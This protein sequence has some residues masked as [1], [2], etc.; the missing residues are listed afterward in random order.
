MKK[1]KVIWT[2]SVLF[3]ALNFKIGRSQDVNLEKIVVTPSRIEE[4]Y[5]GS[6]RKVDVVTAKEIE[7][8]G[9]SNIAEALTDITSVN[10]SDY[11]GPGA[12]KT[13]KMRGSSASQVLVLVDGRSINS[14]RDGEVDLSSL[15]MDNTDRI[16]VMHG[17][18]SSLY[19]AGGMGGV[20]N[21]ITKNPPKE[22]Q[23]TEIISSFGTYRT[24][25]ERILHG[26]RISKLG[27]LLT[28]GYQS[29]EGIRDNSAFY[30]KDLNAKFDYQL[31]D[32]NDLILNSGFYRSDVGA[33]GTIS[34]PDI[35]D[36]QR[37]LKNF[38]DLNWKYKPDAATAFSAKIYNNYDRLEFMENTGGSVYETAFSKSIH[39]TVT[40][41][42]DLQFNRQLFE[43]YH[44]ITGFNYLTNKNDSTNTVK[45]K[46]IVRAGYLENQLDLA[47]DLRLNLGARLD[48]Y[49]NFGLEVNPSVS[50]LYKLSQVNKMHGSVSRSF[51]AP[52]FNDLYWPDEGYQKGNADLK[53]EKAI[54]SE[55]G[56]ES[57]LNKNFVVDL[58]Y[59][60]SKYSELINWAESSGV[61]SPKNIGSAVIDGVEL[62]NKAYLTD[63]LEFDLGYT[64]LNAKDAKTRKYLIY[65]PKNKVDFS[66]KINDLNGFLFDLKGQ[67]T[68]RRFHDP[69]NTIF[70]KRFFLFGVSL[71]KKFKTGPTYFASIDNLFGRKYQTRRDYPMPGFSVTSG[72]KV[73][74]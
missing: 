44:V 46:Y 23:K 41:G 69:D 4:S 48:D 19:G 2:I 12:L 24:Y 14:P 47:K 56:V 51:R 33:P 8:S 65:Q 10:I 1:R 34:S 70:V 42:L 64:F 5:E 26:A 28:G 73:D 17:P 22:K 66:L 61:W 52:T 27:Y 21:I 40:R 67:F 6:A 9:S 35:D 30:A 11:G 58:T 3:I 31:N 49:S 32:Y 29:S 53:P 15:P 36:K 38:L 62:E 20:V 71:S 57:R 63:N 72:L 25:T 59:Y 16:E 68:D 37:N 60:R 43:N 50:F 45:H 39:A 74:F 54:N 18:G 7:S 13:I 55:L